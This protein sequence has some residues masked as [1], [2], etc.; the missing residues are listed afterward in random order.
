MCQMIHKPESLFEQTAT[1]QCDLDVHATTELR[2]VLVAIPHHRS[3]DPTQKAPESFEEFLLP[4]N[5]MRGVVT[6]I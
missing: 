5:R 4:A 3:I 2:R 6:V 1:S